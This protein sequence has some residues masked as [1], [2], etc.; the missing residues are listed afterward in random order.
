ML[1]HTRSHTQE[2][3]VG[4]PNCGGIYA[5]NTKFFDHCIRQ[6]PLDCE[7]E[8]FLLGKVFRLSHL[9][10]KIFEQRYVHYSVIQYLS[11]SPAQQFQC[12]HCSRRYANE[13]LLR[14]HVR[15][16]INHYKCSQCEM[17]VPNKSTLAAHI[18]YRHS[19]HR[20]HKCPQ[21]GR[22]YVLFAV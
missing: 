20:P 22:G 8:N 15:H 6:I 14:D 1:N 17:T 4:C 9:C 5:S 13:R 19:S 12:S 10:L 21:C 16:H 2:K 11:S 18:R 7:W 3:L